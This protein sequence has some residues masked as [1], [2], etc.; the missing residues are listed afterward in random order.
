MMNRSYLSKGTGRRERISRYGV[1][2]I[3]FSYLAQEITWHIQ[4][5]KST[6][7]WMGNKPGA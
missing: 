3:L 6:S 4:G 2:G 5:F 7:E 1:A